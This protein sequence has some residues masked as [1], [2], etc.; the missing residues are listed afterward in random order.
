MILLAV[1]QLGDLYGNYVPVFTR[2]IANAEPITLSAAK[3]QLQMP[4][5]Q[6][7]KRRLYTPSEP[8]V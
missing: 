8:K 2:E 1:N 3:V 4:F 6:K 7:R 5:M